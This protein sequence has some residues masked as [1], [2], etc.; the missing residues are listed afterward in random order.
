MRNERGDG[1]V[2]RKRAQPGPRARWP[3]HNFEYVGNRARL[4]GEM[5]NEA[6]KLQDVD[7]GGLC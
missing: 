5:M 1:N 4:A 6:A 3:R 2:V 7:E